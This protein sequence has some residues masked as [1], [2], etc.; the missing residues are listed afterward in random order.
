[1]R[2][3]FALVLIAIGIAADATSVHA[4]SCQCVCSYDNYGHRYCRQVCRQPRYEPAPQ[5]YPP[6]YQSGPNID[7]DLARLLFGAAV[8]AVIAL[9]A[10][11]FSGSSATNSDA[12]EVDRDTASNNRIKEELEAAGRK[13]DAHIA[14]MLAKYRDGGRHG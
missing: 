11:V 10:G 3:F 5:Y 4:Q 2:T 9:I 13:A 1:M 7:P 14:A 12:E 6:Q 8:V